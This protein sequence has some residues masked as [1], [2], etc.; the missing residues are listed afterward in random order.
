MGKRQGGEGK[1]IQYSQKKLRQQQ[2]FCRFLTEQ[3]EKTGEYMKH[4]FADIGSF[5]HLV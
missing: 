4:L 1:E 2:N 3:P 5:V